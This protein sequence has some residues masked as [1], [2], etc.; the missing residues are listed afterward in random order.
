MGIINRYFDKFGKPINTDLAELI[1]KTDGEENEFGRIGHARNTASGTSY[2]LFH[3]T[4]E[5]K[6][7]VKWGT[8]NIG[9]SW[10]SDN[11]SLDAGFIS[12]IQKR[13]NKSNPSED[14]LFLPIEF[15]I[16][17]GKNPI[18]ILHLSSIIT[19]EVDKTISMSPTTDVVKSIFT[20]LEPVFAW[21]KLC[22]KVVEFNK[23]DEDIINDL[24]SE[25]F[26]DAEDYEIA[27]ITR[28]KPFKCYEIAITTKTIKDGGFIDMDN[29]VLSLMKDIPNIVGHLEEYNVSVSFNTTKPNKDVFPGKNDTFYK[30]QAIIIRILPK[31]IAMIS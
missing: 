3:F 4:K 16:L 10:M 6:D 29:E 2:I 1:E 23:L 25:A 24:F 8:E 7:I 9:D 18:L 28:L 22:K 17:K 20:A 21:A 27:L 30:S 14:Q 11:T 12:K 19:G 13:I 31:K 26:D 5:F 15:S